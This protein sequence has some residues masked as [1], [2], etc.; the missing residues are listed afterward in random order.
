MYIKT[1]FL[2]PIGL[3]YEFADNPPQILLFDENPRLI[4]GALEKMSDP[5]KI[6]ELLKS[7]DKTSKDIS[8]AIGRKG[9]YLYV[10]LNRLCK[11]HKIVKLPTG[12]YGIVDYQHQEDLF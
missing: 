9:T 4:A 5:V 2:K 6:V 11:S 7:G 1:A 12:K 10:T 8:D 3:K